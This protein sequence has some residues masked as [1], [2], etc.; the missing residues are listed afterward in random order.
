MTVNKIKSIV[1]IAEEFFEERPGYFPS[2]A[3]KTVFLLGILT[4]VLLDAQKRERQLKNKTDAPFRKHLKGLNLNYKDMEKL[5]PQVCE[6]LAIWNKGY[7]YSDL[8]EAI[9]NYWTA[10]LNPFPLSSNR[11]SFLFT[12]GLHSG[13]IYKSRMKSENLENTDQKEGTHE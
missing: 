12:L 11:I 5:Y 8:K 9:T 7:D 6:K 4:D 1:D 10:S 3:E 13:L 2:S